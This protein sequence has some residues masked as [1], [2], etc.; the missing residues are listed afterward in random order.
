MTYEYRVV[1]VLPEYVEDMLNQY[2]ADGWSLAFAA[3][4]S[5]G[6]VFM[7]VQKAVSDGARKVNKRT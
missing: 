3:M 7:V 6:E 1:H 2:G 5:S 4:Q